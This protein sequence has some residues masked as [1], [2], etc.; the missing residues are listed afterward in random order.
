MRAVIQRVSRARVTVEGDTTGAIEHGL[1]LYLGVA[2]GDG[3]AEVEWL[4]RK[5]AELRIFGDAEGRI[6]RSVEEAGGSVLVVPQFT[7]Y[8]DT[9][10]GRRPSFFDAAPPDVAEQLVER[11][12]AELRDRGVPVE[13]GRFGAHMLVESENDGPVTI[14]LDSIDIERPRRG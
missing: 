9:R 12:I 1:L 5:V 4:V 10:K 8:A 7:L 3:P 6:D 13:A 2:S 14:L 11:V